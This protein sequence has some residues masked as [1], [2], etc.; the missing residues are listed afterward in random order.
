MPDLNDQVNKLKALKPPSADK[1][2]INGMLAAALS[3]GISKVAADPT[4]LTATGAGPFAA[5]NATATKY[6]LKV[7][8]KS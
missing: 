5:A 8:G 6:G 3:S 7:C 4:L 2:T 1:D